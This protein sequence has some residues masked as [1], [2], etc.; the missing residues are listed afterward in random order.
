MK[1]RFLLI[2]ILAL[3]VVFTSFAA[4]ADNWYYNAQIAEFSY[5]GLKNINEAEISS[6]LYE[7]RYKTF[8]DE[9]FSDI[10]EK[11]YNIS[12]IDFFTAEAEHIDG[13]NDL[14]IAFEFYEIPM[15]S[16]VS[17][18][19]NEVVKNKELKDAVTTLQVGAF[20]DPS[21]KA[22]IEAAKQE[23]VSL[24]LSKG[25]QEAPVSYEITE[26]SESNTYSIVFN[27]TEGYQ[28]RIVSILFSGNENI[29][30]ATLK[31]QVSSKVKSLFNNGFLDTDQLRKDAQSIASYY[32]TNGYI[33]VIIDEP[34]I[35]YV[36]SSNEKF[37][38]VNVIFQIYEG[39][40]WY[41]GCR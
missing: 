40:K 19:G 34:I 8:S 11:L 26:D 30:N 28:T 24:Y 27:L 31:K 9:L 17:F 10:Q 37:K 33:D 18:N 7:F 23:I 2:L 21:S 3:I 41:Y 39:Q 38:E 5:T 25:F 22:V 14:R 16:G 12:G 4:D 35:E 29:D 15:I 6:A 1:K 36:E 13:S 20:I 32:Q